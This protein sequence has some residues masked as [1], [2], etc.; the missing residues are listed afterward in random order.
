MTIFSTWAQRW[1]IPA[2][3]IVDLHERIGVLDSD[4]HAVQGEGRSESAVS[5]AVRMEASK[6][7]D[8]L[9]RNNLGAY[10]D[11]YGNFIRYGLCNDTPALNKKI[12]S[13]D[14]I[15]IHQLLITPAHVGRTI[16]QFDSCEVKHEGWHFTGT[17]REE[18]Q[19]A[20]AELVISL[21]GRARFVNRPGQV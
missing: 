13:G 14:L 3:A 9:W 4:S 21:G 6:K 5:N 15:G 2:I 12:K 20:W 19:Q 16:G 1:N 18:A 17:P 11:E 7:G 8:R 10:K